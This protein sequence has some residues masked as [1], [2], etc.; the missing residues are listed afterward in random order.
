MPITSIGSYVPTINGF[1]THWS[2]VNLALGAG[3]PLILPGSVAIADLSDLGDDLQAFGLS[4]AGKLNDVE[5]ARQS[6]ELSKISLMSRL[7]EFNRKVRGFLGHTA[8]VTAL[9]LVP[10]ASSGPG[11]ILAALDDMVTLWGKVNAAT[12]PGF[13]GPLLLLNSYALATFSIDLTALKT[14]YAT[15][16]AADQEV[17]LERERRNVAQLR[18]SA[19]LVDYRKAVIGTFD[20]LDALVISLPKLSPEPGSTPDAVRATGVWDVPTQQAKITFAASASAN[21]DHYELRMSPG[22]T[23]ST[24]NEA[25]VASLSPSDPVEFFTDAGLTSSGDVASFKVYVVTTIDNEAGSN[26]VA[27]ARP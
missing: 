1:K 2:A 4:I 23:Y 13:T 22:P 6:M 9:P 11:T 15:L 16:Q 7:G 19:M 3:R 8:F 14:A 27:V 26:A 12:I 17:T 10:G 25:V 21:I 18:A 20:P 24:E 5:I